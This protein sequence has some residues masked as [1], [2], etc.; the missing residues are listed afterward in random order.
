MPIEERIESVDQ[1]RQWTDTIPFQ[2]EYTAGVA[3]EK[4][5]RGLMEGRIL[6]GYCLNCEE[7]SL[8][9]RMYCVRC[10]GKIEKAV[11]VPPVGKVKA[12][13]S[14]GEAGPKFVF[15][16]FKGFRGGMIHRLLGKARVGSEVV[17]KFRPKKQRT[18]SVNDIQ[19]FEP[20]S[21]G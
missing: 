16:T 18:G 14:G 4:F 13:T 9:L 17:A 8:P 19:G 10:Y 11:R 6:A 15:V 7:S 3:G 5:L 1:I 2:Y 21:R 20:R 12:V